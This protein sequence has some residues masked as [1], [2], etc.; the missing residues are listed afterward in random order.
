MFG[1]GTQRLRQGLKDQ[2][3]DSKIGAGMD[4]FTMVHGEAKTLLSLTMSLFIGN[5]NMNRK[6][7]QL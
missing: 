2:G 4:G 6:L 1:V 7:L 5:V 3:R